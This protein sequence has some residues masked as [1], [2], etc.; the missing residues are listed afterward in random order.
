M[1]L[2]ICEHDIVQQ[3]RCL[4]TF[5]TAWSRLASRSRVANAVARGDDFSVA[6]SLSG[7]LVNDVPCVW[8]G[9]TKRE[10]GG[11][12]RSQWLHHSIFFI[13]DWSLWSSKLK[14]PWKIAVWVLC[15]IH[16][17]TCVWYLTLHSAAILSSCLKSCILSLPAWLIF[18]ACVTA[19][20]MV[21]QPLCRWRFLHVE[22]WSLA[23]GLGNQSSLTTRL[24]RDT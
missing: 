14:G 13:G 8:R 15:I 2:N 24:Y 9:D 19:Y 3:N 4:L 21:K 12:K 22:D 1:N 5:S 23:V 7:V 18:T 10:K 17:K 20:W 11:L 16:T 6:S